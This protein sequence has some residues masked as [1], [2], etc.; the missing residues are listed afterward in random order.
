MDN[1]TPPAATPEQ[2]AAPA[3]PPANPVSKKP[4]NRFLKWTLL[5]GG[6]LLAL[7]VVAVLTLDFWVDAPLRAGIDKGMNWAAQTPCALGKA[8]LKPWSG[9]I[10]LEKLELGNPDGCREKEG[11]KNL[12]QFE[13]GTVSVQVGSLTSD[14]I[15]VDEVVFDGIELT[16]NQHENG[17]WNYEIV[18]ESLMR[19]SGGDGKQPPEQQPGGKQ[20]AISV[21]LIK[22]TNTKVRVDLSGKLGAAAMGTRELKLSNFEM[23]DVASDD[24]I[25][26]LTTKVIQ[27]LLGQAAKELPGQLGDIGKDLGKS[28]T[29]SVGDLG[30]EVLEGGKKAVEGI[31]NL[32]K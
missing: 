11:F 29:K 17:K 28:L 21:K 18:Q 14:R 5:S 26:S 32:F 10:H 22:F 7:L 9:A 27:A 6:V 20:K 30:G 15:V 24:G 8:D 19:L 12:V 16:M 25:P 23:R 1:P 2:P 31:K 3:N 13:K 4:M